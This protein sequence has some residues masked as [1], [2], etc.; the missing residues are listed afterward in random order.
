MFGGFCSFVVF[1]EG[2]RVRVSDGFLDDLVF[3]R[4]EV[5]VFV[6]WEWRLLV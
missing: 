3:L 4:L 6:Y 1:W 2:I 5:M